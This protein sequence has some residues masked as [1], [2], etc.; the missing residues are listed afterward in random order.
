MTDT[1][2]FRQSLENYKPSDDNEAVDRLSMLKFLASNQDCFVRTNPWA[3]FTGSAL[4]MNKAGDKVL[5]NH[6][7]FLNMWLQFGGHADGE[8]D[9]FAVARREVAEESG[10]DDVMPVIDGIF[11]VSIHGVPY[12]HAKAESSHLH[13]DV[14]YFFRL[15]NDDESFKISDESHDLRWCTYDEAL[16]LSG[17]GSIKRMLDK[18]KAV[19]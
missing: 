16:A 4:L 8:P 10:F 19:A 5:L 1:S 18:W 2:K 17:P 7:R 6:H 14:R 12:N 11:D 13:Y 15:N 9:L 3:H